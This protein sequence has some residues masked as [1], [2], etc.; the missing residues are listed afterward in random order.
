MKYL[1]RFGKFITEK[2]EDV[3]IDLTTKKQKKSDPI[4]QS[5][6]EDVADRFIELMKEKGDD[7]K[8]YIEKQ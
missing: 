3:E 5:T 8:K 2:V 1:K 6:A 7:I 4:K